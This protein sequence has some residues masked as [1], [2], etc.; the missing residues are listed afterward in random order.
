MRQLAEKNRIS[1]R[2]LQMGFAL[3]NFAVKD[4]Y[5]EE[6]QQYVDTKLKDNLKTLQE[7]LRRTLEGMEADR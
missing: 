2:M 5:K 6:R 4:T 7:V 3:I 1:D